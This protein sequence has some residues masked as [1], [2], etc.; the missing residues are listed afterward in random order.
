MRSQPSYV[1]V[2]HSCIMYSAWNPKDNY[3]MSA[4]VFVVKL[5][6]KYAYFLNDGI[7][8]YLMELLTI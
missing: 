2:G 8:Y 5:N 7:R 3:D 6:G 1:S 4:S